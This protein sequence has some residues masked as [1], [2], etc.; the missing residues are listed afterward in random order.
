MTP[1]DTPV[2]TNAAAT[3]TNAAPPTADRGDT[4]TTWL[5]EAAAADSLAVF[6]DDL[7]DGWLGPADPQMPSFGLDDATLDS[8]VR[9][10]DQHLDKMARGD[11]TRFSFNPVGRMAFNR[12]QGPVKSQRLTSTTSIIKIKRLLFWAREIA[13]DK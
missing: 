8:L 9:V 4:S 13:T 3:A 1:P 11:Y 6:W 2:A 10:S 7:D 5:S 12:V